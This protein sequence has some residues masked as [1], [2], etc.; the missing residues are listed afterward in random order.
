MSFKADDIEEQRD[1][2][3]Q[4]RDINRTLSGILA[5]IALMNDLTPQQLIEI[6]EDN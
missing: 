2:K 4:L 5:G 1:I 6:A 3:S